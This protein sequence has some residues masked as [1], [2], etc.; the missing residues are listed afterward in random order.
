MPRSR[1]T[2][3][4]APVEATP[5]ASFGF[6]TARMLADL[7]VPFDEIDFSPSSNAP[8]SRTRSSRVQP[9]TPAA[10]TATTV[11]TP[12]VLSNPSLQPAAQLP[13]PIPVTTSLQDVV[14]SPNRRKRGATA[15]TRQSEARTARKLQAANLRLQALQLED[16]SDTDIESVHDS[17]HPPSVSWHHE[18]MGALD[19][20]HS[21]SRE[22]SIVADNNKLRDEMREMRQAMQSQSLA[23]FAPKPWTK[24]DAF[25]SHTSQ[26]SSSLTSTAPQ[27]EL[28]TDNTLDGLGVTRIK[29]KSMEAAGMLRHVAHLVSSDPDTTLKQGMSVGY[30]SVCSSGAEDITC[31]LQLT[32]SKFA[33]L[34]AAGFYP[35][36]LDRKYFSDLSTIHSGYILDELLLAVRT[37][38]PAD[39]PTPLEGSLGLTSQ[40]EATLLNLFYVLDITYKLLPE[41]AEALYYGLVRKPSHW[42]RQH[43][44]GS[45]PRNLLVADKLFNHT[46]VW[47]QN[48]HFQIAKRSIVTLE[49]LI[50]LSNDGPNL[51]EVCH[52]FVLWQKLTHELMST[53]SADKLAPLKP[54]KD[55]KNPKNPKGLPGVALK[56]PK[57]PNPPAMGVGKLIKEMRLPYCAAAVFVGANPC[58]PKTCRFEHDPPAAGTPEAESL[59][60]LKAK[61][62]TAQFQPAFDF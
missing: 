53:P 62:P 24:N 37:D 34:V 59:R 13:I 30:L 19:Y 21:A 31:G 17:G 33:Q 8:A 4:I 46:V 41:L 35:S 15:M 14:A 40:L 52:P 1:R 3:E 26:T 57:N 51:N 32:R 58:D 7:E 38:T 25:K 27:M 2:P 6:R 42:F 9:V 45:G 29:P 18:T 44:F 61:Y 12:T 39:E 16:Q 54:L 55:P 49:A 56:N 50:T 23:S 10:E 48:V 47:L 60:K 11:A 5:S 28:F 36:G 22:S 43:S 20:V